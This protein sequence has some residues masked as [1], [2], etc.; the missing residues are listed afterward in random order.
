[1]SDNKSNAPGKLTDKQKRFGD[2]YLVDLNRTQAAIRAGYAANSANEQGS[3]LLAKPAIQ[4]YIQE[5]QK[6]IKDKLEITQEMISREYA[7]I[8]FI[9]IRK[10]YDANGRLLLP[11]ELDDDAAASLAGIDVDE[12]WGYEPQ[13]EAKVKIGETKK[14]RMHSKQAALDSL[15]KHVG[16]FEKDNEQNKPTAV[17][18]VE[19]VIKNTGVPLASSE[20][21]IQD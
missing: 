7:K 12:I 3:Q 15:A 4:H 2:E 14:I 20:K 6:Q 13:A 19:V 1:M 10:F 18:T 5:R 17:V 8:A 21:D 16:F 9:D 11:H